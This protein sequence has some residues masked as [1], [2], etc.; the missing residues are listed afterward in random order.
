MRSD[1]SP[2]VTASR[3]TARE[4][5]LL[6][7]TLRLL[8][9]HGYDGLTVDAVA[10]EA[11]SSKATIYRGW[12]SKADLVLAAFIAG[13]RV[14]LV[15]PRTGTLRDDLL[16]LGASVCERARRHASTLS[17]VMVEMAHNPPLKAAL[18]DEFFDSVP[19]FGGL[20]IWRGLRVAIN[21]SC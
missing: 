3:W 13:A 16:Q 14:Q 8:Q 5:E 6:A 19:R 4:A 15:P 20:R 2:N 11:K 21:E 17:A 12:P 9:Q 7:V 18:Q 10:N 1:S